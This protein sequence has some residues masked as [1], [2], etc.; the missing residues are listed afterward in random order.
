MLP[1]RTSLT[2][3][4]AVLPVLVVS[5]LE[6]PVV[7]RRW[8]ETPLPG[9]TTIMACFAFELTLSR[10]ITPALAHGSV[11]STLTTRATISALPL[12]G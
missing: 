1:L 12:K 10:I 8:K 4:G 9:V 6:P 11:F 5:V 7:V 3:Y 2:Q